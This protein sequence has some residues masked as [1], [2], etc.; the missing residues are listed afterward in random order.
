MQSV[1][2]ETQF[3]ERAVLFGESSPDIACAAEDGY[4]E[5]KRGL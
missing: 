2:V 3:Q 5:V 1:L 4:T